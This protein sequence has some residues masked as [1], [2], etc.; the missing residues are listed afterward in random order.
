MNGENKNGTS[1]AGEGR[2][3]DS[4]VAGGPAA[5]APAEPAQGAETALSN[6]TMAAATT[7]RTP[8]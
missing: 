1:T 2:G 5:T 8:R 3:G 4:A 6:R 7:D